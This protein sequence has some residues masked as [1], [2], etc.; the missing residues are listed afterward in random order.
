MDCAKQF[1]GKKV[2]DVMGMEHEME[3]MMAIHQG[4]MT[5]RD[6]L[7]PLSGTIKDNPLYQE[8]LKGR[9]TKKGGSCDSGCHAKLVQGS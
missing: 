3:V 8:W 1:H 7:D 9:E 5:E 6:P 2:V 4:Y